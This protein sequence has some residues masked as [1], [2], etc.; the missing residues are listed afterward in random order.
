MIESLQDLNKSLKNKLTLYFG[1]QDKIIE[2]LL[3]KD[4]EIDGVVFNTD[5]TPYAIK[6]DNDIVKVCKKLD[7]K[8]FRFS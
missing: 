1:E 3:K 4:Q 8:C 6:R 2:K 7:K 5:Y